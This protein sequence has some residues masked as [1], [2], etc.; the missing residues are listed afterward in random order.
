MSR[1]F[2]PSSSQYLERAS[3]AIAS[4]PF[5]FGIWFKMNDATTN[6]ALFAIANSG[7]SVDFWFLQARG[8]DEGDPVVLG[9]RQNGGA[10]TQADTSTGF[11]TG[12][13]HLAVGVV[14]ATND[15]RV[16][17]N[18]GSKGTNT[19]NVTPTGLNT[20]SIG[21]LG[22]ATPGDYCD[23]QFACAFLYGT[24]L[25]DAQ[26]ADLYVAKHPMFIRPNDLV[27]FWPLLNND[28]SLIGDYDLTA[29]NSPTHA[30]HPPL[31]N[32]IAPLSLVSS[33]TSPGG[34]SS[35]MRD[36]RLGASK[37][38]NPLKGVA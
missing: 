25:S 35:S 5:T 36:A 32:P 23:G 7:T 22:D 29:F 31:N 34:G 26:V 11:S 27:A 28:A 33:I 8:E 18:G 14:A 17:I 16:F 3:A 37:P 1:S 24:A 30:D 2:T 10:Y 4:P 6:Q 13:W 21:R 12:E 38:L 19:I 9:C 20:T 15:R